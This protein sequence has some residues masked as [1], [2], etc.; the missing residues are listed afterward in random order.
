M[1]EQLRQALNSKR[2]WSLT[3]YGAIVLLCIFL[4]VLYMVVTFIG[5][6]H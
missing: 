3:C 6:H 1:E 4:Y 2:A 5:S